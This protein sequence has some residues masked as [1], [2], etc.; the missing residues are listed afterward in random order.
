MK[1]VL[2]IS[3]F[4][5]SMVAHAQVEKPYNL[6]VATF[7][8][9][10]FWCVEADFEKLDGVVQV[11]SGY[12]GGEKK[13]PTYQQ[14]ASG[15]TK[16][17]EAVQVYYRPSIISYRGLLDHLW[18]SINPT[19]ANGQFVD[20]GKQYRSAI[21]YHNAA[22]KQ[23]AEASIAALNAASVFDAAIVTELMPLTQF[24]IAEDNHQDYYVRH[25]WRYRY[26]RHR[27]GRDQWL[28]KVWGSKRK[29][30]PNRDHLKSSVA[31]V[32]ATQFVTPS[33]Y[34]LKKALTK[35]QYRVTQEDAT[36]PAFNNRYWDE[37][38]DGI[39]VDVVSGEPLFSS[40]DKY[41]SGTGWPS[42]TQ[43]IGGRPLVKKEDNSLF[44]TRIEVRSP[45]ADSHLGHVFND[46]P[47]P[48]GLRYCINSAA[49]RFIPKQPYRLKVMALI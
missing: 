22:Q 47:K 41:R 44:M 2:V 46:G 33:E 21:F 14:V 35:L 27:S 29:R 37:K 28:D 7:A 5:F 13:N 45:M 24:Y 15:Q 19:D 36:E 3:L 40:N 20:R 32:P 9:G 18:R 26:Y 39:Y 11:V 38:R 4:V 42:F 17:I 34:Y 43:A 10:C 49:L 23:L 1:M 25:A 8:G 6:S 31:D 48:S 16:H 12:T 30:L